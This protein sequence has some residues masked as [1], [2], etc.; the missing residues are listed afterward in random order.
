MTEAA[1]AEKPTRTRG[2]PR[3]EE[4][5]VR[6]DTALAKIREQGG[7]TTRN[8]LH[9]SLGG[10][11]AGVKISQAY[12]S[13]VRLRTAGLVERTRDG[14]QHVWKLTSKAAG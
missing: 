7:T 2:R 12:L 14:S 8:K 5:I 6:D 4:T 3:P 10:D 1:V 13:L 11:A 9:E